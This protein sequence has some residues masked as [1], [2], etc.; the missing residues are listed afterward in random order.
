MKYREE[1]DGVEVASLPKAKALTV[2]CRK[3]HKFTIKFLSVAILFGTSNS[4]ES[5]DVN[6]FVQRELD[7]L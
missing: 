5:M 1:N 4:S 2:P 3:V 7:V 6:L